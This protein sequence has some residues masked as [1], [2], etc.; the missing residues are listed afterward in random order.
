MKALS[1]TIGLISA[2]SLAGCGQSSRDPVNV[3][4]GHPNAGDDGRGFLRADYRRHYGD[5]KSIEMRHEIE[6]KVDRAIVLAAKPNLIV[7][8]AEESIRFHF[9]TSSDNGPLRFTLMTRYG[10]DGS[11]GSIGNVMAALKSQPF[12]IAYV[13]YLLGGGGPDWAQEVSNLMGSFPGL[14]AGD[15]LPSPDDLIKQFSQNGANPQQIVADYQSEL[16]RQAYQKIQAASTEAW[17]HQ[18]SD[19]QV[20]GIYRSM[21][22]DVSPS[23]AANGDATWLGIDVVDCPQGAYVT[24]IHDFPNFR[25]VGVGNVITEIDGASIRTANDFTQ[26]M[27]RHQPGDHVALIWFANPMSTA[28]PVSEDVMLAAKPK[29]GEDIA[30]PATSFGAPVPPSQIVSTITP[31][32]GV[33]SPSRG[34]GWLGLQVAQGSIAP[35][36]MA[37]FQGSPTLGRLMKGDQ[38]V[39]AT[40]STG[41]HSFHTPADLIAFTSS[42]APGDL[43]T[44]IIRR[45]FD[46]LKVSLVLGSRPN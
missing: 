32:P 2:L 46:Q 45:R 24:A 34:T 33:P 4:V 30:P 11:A 18:L 38:I 25:R 39:G 8:A 35:V 17:Q 29:S 19:A 12:K 14:P 41:M 28:A 44:L 36:A 26:A 9:Q 22:A 37:A 31:P 43:I 6:I 23:A 1:I 10:V 21:L 3:D 40:D 15:D 27:A 16:T 42:H 13:H 7:V 20:L 5:Y